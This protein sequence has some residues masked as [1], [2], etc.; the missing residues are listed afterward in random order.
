MVSVIGQK[1][2]PEN[3]QKKP[4]NC[5]INYIKFITLFT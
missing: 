2:R 5:G 1:N 3:S 4:C